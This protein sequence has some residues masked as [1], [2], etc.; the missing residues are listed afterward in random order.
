MGFHFPD[1]CA[2]S[3]FWFDIDIIMEQKSNSLY[4]SREFTIPDP[5]LSESEIFIVPDDD[6]VCSFASFSV[7]RPELRAVF[8]YTSEI[9]YILYDSF[10][11]VLS[12]GGFPF[13]FWLRF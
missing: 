1:V 12:L 7:A 10:S 13:S 5:H 6:A 3:I 2:Q 4:V 8:C 11:L 9:V